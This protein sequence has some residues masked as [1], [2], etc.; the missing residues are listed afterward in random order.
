MRTSAVARKT[1]PDGV[2]TT[3]IGGA[4]E[5]RRTGNASYHVFIVPGEHGP[6]TQVVYTEG[7]E[8]ELSASTGDMHRSVS[9]VLDKSL[10]CSS[11]ASMSRSAV[12][13]PRMGRPGSSPE[14]DQGRFHGA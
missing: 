5:L 3:Y 2:Q 7:G 11:A 13:S 4:Y 14:P 8:D 12:A 9:V 10:E 6:V 1:D